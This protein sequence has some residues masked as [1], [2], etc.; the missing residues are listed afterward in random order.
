MV[1]VRTTETSQDL[2][3]NLSALMRKFAR[4]RRKDCRELNAVPGTQ[5]ETVTWGNKGNSIFPC[6]YYVENSLRVSCTDLGFY[7]PNVKRSSSRAF[8]SEAH[9]HLEKDAR[10]S[11]FRSEL[12]L[13]I[14]IKYPGAIWAISEASSFCYGEAYSWRILP[15]I[16]GRNHIYVITVDWAAKKISKISI[17]A[18]SSTT[19]TTM[20]KTFFTGP[21]IRWKNNIRTRL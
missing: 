13:C 7:F 15:T 4:P 14:G 20:I 6:Y 12:K 3:G 1:N 8:F 11:F 16:M 2:A 18:K 21:M 17:V 5:Y 9:V 10:L 19:I